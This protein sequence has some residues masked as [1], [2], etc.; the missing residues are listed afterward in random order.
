MTCGTSAT[1]C[2]NAIT[3]WH[4]YSL[5]MSGGGRST[6]CN[7][8]EERLELLCVSTAPVIR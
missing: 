2:F 8:L 5:R 4:L 1:N 7:T 6:P 3:L